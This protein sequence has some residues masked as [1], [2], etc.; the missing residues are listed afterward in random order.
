MPSNLYT[1]YPQLDGAPGALMARLILEARLS[2][3]D[4]QI[5]ASR[6]IW[7]MDYADIAVAVHMDRTAVS[8]RLRQ[9]IVPRLMAVWPWV[10]GE[11]L[12]AK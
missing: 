10:S 8:D 1:E 9:Q 6:L 5:A 4:V 3:R 12:N 2:P 11:M 7:G